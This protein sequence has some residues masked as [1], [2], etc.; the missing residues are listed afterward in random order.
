MFDQDMPI[1]VHF[2]LFLSSSMKVAF[3]SG[4]VC[5]KDKAESRI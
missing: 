3:L 5:L 2:H 1:V 4:L